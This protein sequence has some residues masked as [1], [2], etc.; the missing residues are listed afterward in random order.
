MLTEWIS[1]LEGECCTNKSLIQTNVSSLGWHR[2]PVVL[3]HISAPR[4]EYHYISVMLGD[5]VNVD[6]IISGK[7]LSGRASPGQIFI[8]AAGQ[9]NSWR[10]D[11]PT[12]EI[13]L[14]ISPLVIE[15]VA[16]EIGHKDV[17]L[18]NQ[19]AT[20][21]NLIKEVLIAL[22]RELR[23]PGIGSLL[24]LESGTQ[25]LIYHLLRS[26]SATNSNYIRRYVLSHLQIKR[27]EQYVE[28]RLSND[29]SLIELA[30]HV[31]MSQFHFARAFKNTVGRPPHSWLT[32]KRVSRARERI[33]QTSL[34]ILEVSNSVGYQSQSHFGQVFKRRT[35]I[36]PIELRKRSRN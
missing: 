3:D 34:S 7:A 9:T 30:S 31:G 6:A 18:I 35:G 4:I 24:L 25:Y 1:S 26:H 15:R 23:Q 22:A 10:W 14:F 5:A 29:I 17:E 21:D 33:E 20:T 13:H 12:E 28:D 32:E 27:L 19:L 11:G 2:F 36:C 16:L 8:M